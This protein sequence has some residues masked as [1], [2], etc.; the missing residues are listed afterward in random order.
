V[1]CSHEE[2]WLQASLWGFGKVSEAMQLSNTVRDPLGYAISFLRILRLRISSFLV[3][4][5]CTAVLRIKGVTLEKNCA[6][7]GT[8]VVVRYPLSMIH[9]HPGCTIRSDLHSN[10]IGLNH[11][12]IIATL[13]K[14]AEI[15][16]GSGTGIS[17]ATIAAAQRVIIGSNVL[18][19]ANVLITDSD[20]HSVT[21][22]G[23]LNQ[24]SKS[25]PVHIE[26]NVWL[27][28]NT[29]VLKGVTIGR[30]SV[31]GA[32]SLVLRDIPPNVVAGGNP[33][34]VLYRL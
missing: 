25:E 22:A 31:I 24:N 30:N 4:Q 13:G 16:I 32:N 33:C 8:P 29:V 19:G 7:F 18:C 2:A 28:V 34:K 15:S 9:I 14:N 17:G 26:D 12:T 21:P 20:W 27:G 6:F 3:S 11:K 23:R 5:W 10:L 1:A